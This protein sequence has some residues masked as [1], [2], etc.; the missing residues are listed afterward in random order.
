M[1]ACFDS[2]SCRAENVENAVKQCYDHIED[3]K[4][5]YGHGGYSGTLAEARG[6]QMVNKTFLDENSAYEWLE[7]NAEKW[8][9]AVGVTIK[10]ESGK[11]IY[12][13]GAICS[14]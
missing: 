6:V 14:E 10:T 3:C 9:P 2:F 11:P 4:Y 12:M 5:Q 8:G 13:F 1:G 7:D